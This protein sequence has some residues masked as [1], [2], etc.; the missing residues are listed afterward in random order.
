MKR[1]PKTIEFWRGKLPH[2]E[3]EDGQYF[4]TIHLHGAIP[5]EGQQRIRAIAK[6][7]KNLSQTEVDAQLRISRQIFIE[8]EAWLDRSDYVNHLRNRPVA[9]MI[10]EAVETRQLRK[11]WEMHEFV[12]MP[13]H[14]HLFFELSEAVTLK[15]TLEDF[16]RWTGH[17]ASKLIELERDRFWQTEW[18]DHWSRSDDED[19]RIVEYIQRNPEKAGLVDTYEQWPYGSWVSRK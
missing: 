14:V 18:F 16:K 13:S 3:V 2:W 9:A 15:Y 19:N 17:Q 10:S 4:V 6:Q 7:F 1:H 8:M 12:V 5:I 11:Q